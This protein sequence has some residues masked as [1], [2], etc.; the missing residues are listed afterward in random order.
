MSNGALLVC[1]H[2]QVCPAFLFT[3]WLWL[4]ILF[5]GLPVYSEGPIFD[6]LID[7][8]SSTTGHPTNQDTN[9]INE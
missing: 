1:P 7:D 4:N 3:S 8:S 2:Q 6:S 5:E 9:L